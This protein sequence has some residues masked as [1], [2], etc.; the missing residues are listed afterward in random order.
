MECDKTG[1]EK[2]GAEDGVFYYSRE[3]GQGTEETKTARGSE[4]EGV[5]KNGRIH[6]SRTSNDRANESLVVIRMCMICRDQSR[7][8]ERRATARDEVMDEVIV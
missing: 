2:D 5:N 6:E 1:A 3:M 7:A 4:S 8:R